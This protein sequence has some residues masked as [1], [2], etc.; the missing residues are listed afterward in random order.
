[1]SE[2]QRGIKE[3]HSNNDNNSEEGAKLVQLLE[4]AA[5]PE[6]LMSEMTSEQLTS[7]ATYQAKLE[8]IRQS[9]IQKSIHKALED[10]GLSAREVTPFMR[11]RVVGLTHKN[12]L[13]SCCPGKGLITI[14]NPTEK[15]VNSN[16]CKV[17][18]IS[19][20]IFSFPYININKVVVLIYSLLSQQLELVEGKAYAVS[21]LMPL[22]SESDTLYL[23]AR[24][25]TTKWVP[26]SLSAT[27]HFE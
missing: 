27:E 11:V 10:A 24:G 23:Q 7:F 5:E 2:F 9:D 6:V 4:T 14:W 19:A 22:S 21:G 17:R 16:S 13:T 26:L 1:M 8:A 25:S 15:Q 3:F 20:S 18:S 12:Y